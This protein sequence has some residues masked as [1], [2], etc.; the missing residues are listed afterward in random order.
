MIWQITIQKFCTLPYQLSL[1]F[2]CYKT[3]FALVF[4]ILFSWQKLNLTKFQQNK[5]LEILFFLMNFYIS[6]KRENNFLKKNT[7]AKTTTISGL[8]K[9]M[10][11]GCV[12]FLK[13]EGNLSLKKKNTQTLQHKINQITKNWLFFF[14]YFKIL[15]RLS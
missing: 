10:E 2:F 9:I 13:R 7:T 4:S 1:L 8:C 3:R 6:F 5:S 15:K 11:F 14:E 12:V